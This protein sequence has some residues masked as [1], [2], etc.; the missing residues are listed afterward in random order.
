M[1]K[2]SNCFNTECSICLET[3]ENKSIII[4][5]PCRHFICMKCFCVGGF[6]LR[7]CPT[8]RTK[9]SKAFVYEFGSDKIIYTISAEDNCPHCVMK[10][11][12]PNYNHEHNPVL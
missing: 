7:K 10:I 3:P 2:S 1:E 11:F 4:K 9:L 8:C 12:N 6:S 5:T